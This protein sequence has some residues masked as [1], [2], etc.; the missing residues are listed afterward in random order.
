MSLR[1][2]P[3]AIFILLLFT[4][5]VSCSKGYPVTQPAVPGISAADEAAHADGSEYAG[6]GH[7]LWGYYDIHLD[8]ADNTAEVIPARSGEVHYN[9]VKFLETSPCPNC[10]L[11]EGMTPSDHGTLLVDVKIVH[12]F[13]APLW[14]GFDV[15]AIAIFN[16]SKP[17]PYSGLVASDHALGDMELI[18][19]DGFTTLYNPTTAGSGP[20]GL[21]GYI[22]G[23]LSTPNDP[24]AQLNGYMR[25]I[26]D[27][28]ANT[29]NAFY[30]GEAITRTL[31]IDFASSPMVFGYAVDGCWVAP[32]STPVDDPM[33]D[34]PPSANCDEPW[35]L[36]VV[37]HPFGPGLTDA[38]GITIVSVDVYDYQGKSSHGP[39]IIE[40]RDFFDN[41][42][43]ATYKS[44]AGNYSHWE[45]TIENQKLAPAGDYKCLIKVVDETNDTSP[46]WLDMTAYSILPITVSES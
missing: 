11:I 44:D 39:P 43:Q 17:F 2:I 42:L 3:F 14:T 45:F 28:P 9:L 20:G 31:D 6:N 19:A 7:H 46:S 29:R 16:G 22:K 1:S 35:W 25:Y 23:K 37:E 41:T 18:N 27:D 33:T 26:S 5:I 10:V 30:A 15:R 38:G 21:Q 4:V 13:G 32:T 24:N 8:L 12:P 40:C 34:F 36:D